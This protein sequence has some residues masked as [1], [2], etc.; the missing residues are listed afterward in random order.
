MSEHDAVILLL[1]LVMRQVS[2]VSRQRTGQDAGFTDSAGWGRFIPC[3]KMVRRCEAIS[4]A[5]GFASSGASSV[6]PPS[7]SHAP[8]SDRSESDASSDA[9]V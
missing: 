6:G 2:H 1:H 7:V 3:L 4:G 5:A 9:E 8:Q